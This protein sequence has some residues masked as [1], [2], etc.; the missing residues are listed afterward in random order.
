LGEIKTI[1]S[2]RADIVSL[3]GVIA[4]YSPRLSPVQAEWLENRFVNSDVGNNFFDAHR[5][6]FQL[7]ELR[8]RFIVAACN[9][10]FLTPAIGATV[11]P[12]FMR[13]ILLGRWS[14]CA[15]PRIGVPWDFYFY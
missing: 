10:E 5:F 2:F 6:D 4:T 13:E 7:S 1:L 14:L 15:T 8:R 3:S 9:P 11:L 12:P